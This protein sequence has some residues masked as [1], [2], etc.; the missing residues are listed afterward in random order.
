M[1][2]LYFKPVVFKDRHE[3]KLILRNL[4]SCLKPQFKITCLE[5]FIMFRYQQQH[6]ESLILFTNVFVNNSG[7]FKYFTQTCSK[8]TF[9]ISRKSDIICLSWALNLQRC[10]QFTLQ[11]SIATALRVKYDIT[12]QFK[13]L[14]NYINLHRKYSMLQT[15]L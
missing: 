3:G 5:C 10:M 4:W 6:S 14:T 1:M 8:L 11:K 9:M 7:N 2:K 13:N 15:T 12:Y